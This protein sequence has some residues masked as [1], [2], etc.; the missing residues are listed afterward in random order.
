MQALQLRPSAGWQWIR[1]GWTLFR[2]QPFGFVALLFCYWLLL[3]GAG[4]VIGWIATG[5]AMA[6]PVLSAELIAA[7]GGIIVA[8]ATPALTVGYLQACRAADQGQRI[9]PGLLFSAFRGNAKALKQLLM[10]GAIQM[11][12]LGCIVLATSGF[13]SSKPVAEPPTA[14]A[15]AEP[16]AK[17]P[18]AGPSTT[19]PAPASPEAAARDR[20]RQEAMQRDAVIGTLQ[21]LAY[22]PI[23]MIM[24][25]APMLAAWHGLPAGK[26]LF[27]SIVAVWRNLGAF[28][29]YG[30]GWMAIFMVTAFV[31]GIVAA[32]FGMNNL[33]AMIALPLIM[34]LLTCMYCSVYPTYSTVLV[35]DGD[36][37]PAPQSAP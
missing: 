23:A 8:V 31:I 25:Y 3:L 21:A 20:A 28:A 37:S 26:A 30:I 32:L 4:K 18:S 35:D 5:L 9:H 36:R 6:L 16:A 29:L 34:L 13:Q 17:A 10:L 12:A 2:K 27:F 1:A 33:S 24:W 22:A 15:P 11:V 14:T 19:T 7:L